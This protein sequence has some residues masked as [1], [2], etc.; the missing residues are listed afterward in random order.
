MAGRAAGQHGYPPTREDV[1]EICIEE[2]L[3][4]YLVL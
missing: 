2:K 3:I 1:E 4:F